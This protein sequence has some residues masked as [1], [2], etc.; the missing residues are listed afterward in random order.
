MNGHVRMREMRR[1]LRRLLKAITALSLLLCVGA[2]TLWA[3]TLALTVNDRFLYLSLRVRHGHHEHSLE[4]HPSGLSVVSVDRFSA[5]SAWA[6]RFEPDTVGVYWGVDAAWEFGGMSRVRQ[7]MVGYD[8][9]DERRFQRVEAYTVP[10]AY[11]CTALAVLPVAFAVGRWRARRARRLSSA[12][13]CRRCG[14]DLRS[15]PDGSGPPLATCPECGGASGTI[16]T[17]R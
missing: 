2:A 6:C 1:M 8:P 11:A 9:D 16:V 15:T 14:Y 13:R 3:N 17:A 7:T 5:A 4:S 10:H 12:N